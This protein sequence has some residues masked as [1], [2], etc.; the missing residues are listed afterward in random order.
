MTKAITQVFELT[1]ERAMSHALSG[2]H[3]AG[4][5]CPSAQF[6]GAIARPFAQKQEGNT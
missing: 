4:R 5:F 1:T 3:C 2:S 6:Y